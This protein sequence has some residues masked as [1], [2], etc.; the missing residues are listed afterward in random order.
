[1]KLRKKTLAIISAMLVGAICILYLTSQTILMNSFDELEKQESSRDVERT[2]SVLF[3]QLSALDAVTYDWAAWD[4]TYEFIEDN[5]PEYIEANI[6]DSTFTGLR[7]NL[8]L[9]INSSNQIHLSKAFDLQD[10]EEVPLPQSLHEYLSD[11]ALLLRH[12]DTESSITGIILLTE[13]PML[14]TS[15]PILTSDDE[16]PIRGTLIMGR[17]LDS[18]EIERLAGVAHLPLTVCR[19]DDSQM[20]SDFQAALSSLSEEVQI[21]I[22]PLSEE[23]IAGY[24]LIDD[25]YG[26]PS[27]VLRAD[28]PRGI[29]EQGQSTTRYFILSLLAIGLVGGVMGILFLERTVLSRLTRLSAS[30]DSIGKSGDISA[31]VQMKGKDELSSLAGAING[32]LASLEQAHK[33]LKRAYEDLKALD[34]MKDE[35]L[36]MTSHELKTPLAPMTSLVRQMSGG[37][38]G[39]LTKKQ[40]KALGIIARGIERLRGSVEKILEISR[41]ESG[42][43]ELHKEKLQLAP[44]VRDVIKRMKPSATLKKISLTQRMAKLP[45]I[46]ADRGRVDE[47]LSC[48]IDN[49][50]KFTP[51]GGRVDVATKRKGDNALIEVK[52]NGKGVAPNDIPKLFKKFF[53]ADPSIPGIGLGLSICKRLVEAHGGKIR[54]ESKLD[55]GSTFS[56]TLPVK[57]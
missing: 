8:L 40:E 1:M 54:C 55:K 33:K 47:V 29:Y 37:E 39:E 30:V 28:M 48:L 22:Q 20:P 9:F 52:D 14:V 7:I 11:N 13:G 25:V 44:L 4:E 16:G 38:L 26:N 27:L 49:A 56:F 23:S 15:R 3:D 10:E 6:V 12:L 24:A 21:F 41:L 53:R 42:R 18:A 45:T 51:E 36:S 34:R 32:M 35:F 50:I 43:M 46:E 19:V 31:R 5:N 2:L 17:Y 57:G